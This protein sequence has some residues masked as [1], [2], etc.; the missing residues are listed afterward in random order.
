MFR[1]KGVEGGELCVALLPNRNPLIPLSMAARDGVFGFS[2]G[3]K[4]AVLIFLRLV[5]RLDMR[6]LFMLRARGGAGVVGT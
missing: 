6:R 5:I 2:I 4:V 1:M 3:F